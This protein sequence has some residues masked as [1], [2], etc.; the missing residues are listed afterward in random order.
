MIPK[1]CPHCQSKPEKRSIFVRYGVYFRSS[2][3]K[4]VRRYKCKVCEKTFS[5]AAFTPFYRS[6]MRHKRVLCRGCLCSGVSQRRTAAE[7]LKVRRSTVV[8]MFK[9]EAAVAEFQLNRNNC[10]KKPSLVIQFDDMETFEHT[11]CKPVSISL[12]VEEGSRR[13]LGLS[14]SRM[15]ANGRLA[16]RSRKKYGAR[17]DERSIGRKNLFTKINHLIAPNALI[18][19]DE[20]PYYAADIKRFFPRAT[21]HKYLGK[22]GAITGQGELKKVVFDPLFSLNHTAAMFRANVNRL[23]RRTWCTTK[24]VDRLYMHLVLYANYH[25]SRLLPRIP[26]A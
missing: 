5:V 25:N 3:K 15:A 18:K 21:H 11:K 26:T 12:A 10:L 19:T 2:D 17:I 23:I 1:Y 24:R 6:R 16:E 13:I 9:A 14:V 20:N 22:R 7:F 8:R 4:S